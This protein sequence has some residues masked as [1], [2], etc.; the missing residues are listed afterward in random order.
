MVELSKEKSGT[1]GRRRHRVQ[2]PRPRILAAP[3]NRNYSSF[4]GTM[5]IVLPAIAVG[6]I[7]LVVAWPRFQTHDEGFHVGLSSI[8]PED[9]QNLRMVSPR[10]QGTDKRGEP[11]T[12]TADTAMKKSPQSDVV[13]LSRPVADITITRGNWIALKA[14]YGVYREQDQQLD[15][16]G[17]VDLYHDDGYEFE[18][19][20]AHVNM[21]NN[22]AEGDDPVYGQGP[23]GTIES[24]G[25]RVYDKGERIIFTG[26]AHLLL[27]SREQGGGEMPDF[28]PTINSNQPISAGKTR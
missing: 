6:I 8:T 27:R 16:I 12:V 18:T 15:L 23:F 19:L 1:E 26:L 9:V 20:A 21:A 7:L 28:M 22:T 4:V 10:Y 17:K 25:F 14:E 5:K 13:E 2:L 24:Q 3:S 11:F